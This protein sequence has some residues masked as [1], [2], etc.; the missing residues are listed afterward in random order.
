MAA[1]MVIG[2]ILS[3]F[4]LSSCESVEYTEPPREE[5][6]VVIEVPEKGKDELFVLANSWAVDAFNSAESVIEFSDKEAG[7]VKGNF[8]SALSDGM[9][10]SGRA[11][12]TM[13]IEVKDGRARISFRDP[14]FIYERRELWSP[15]GWNPCEGRYL[16]QLNLH[17]DALASSLGEA[18][19]GEATEW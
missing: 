12:T 3:V 8:E 9:R 19:R 1:R 11:R 17:W 2:I 15:V 16:Q 6:A 7:I 10:S 13:T 5:Q 18:L 14:M 4:A